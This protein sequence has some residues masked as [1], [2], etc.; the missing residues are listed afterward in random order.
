[1]FSVTIGFSLSLNLVGILGM[2]GAYYVLRF[3][4]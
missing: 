1:M 4:R 3:W 2:V